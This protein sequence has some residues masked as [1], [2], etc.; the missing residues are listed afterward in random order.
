VL[1]IDDEEPLVRLTAN[2]LEDLGYVPTGFMS[3]A[4]ALDSFRADPDRFDAVITDERMPG[5]SGTEL[6]RQ[7]REVR[8]AI[9]I[10]LVTGYLSTAVASGARAAGADE[11][12][13]KPLALRE[14][15]TTMARALQRRGMALADDEVG[16]D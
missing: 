9:P 13:R 2:A 7:I 12:L 3:G 14:L 10:V 6:I 1:V 11:V 5:I 15:A 8:S 4:R 16:Q